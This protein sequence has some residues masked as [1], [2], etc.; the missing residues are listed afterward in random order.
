M[1]LVRRM[2]FIHINKTECRITYNLV[3]TY[4]WFTITS[5]ATVEQT[6]AKHRQQTPNSIRPSATF[7][8]SREAW[9][10]LQGTNTALHCATWTA[11]QTHRSRRDF[12]C[13]W[14]C[15]LQRVINTADFEPSSCDWRTPPWWYFIKPFFVFVASIY[16]LNSDLDWDSQ[17]GLDC[18][19]FL[20]LLQVWLPSAQR[21]PPGHELS[22]IYVV[23]ITNG[24]LEQIEGFYLQRLHAVIWM[25]KFKGAET[26][27]NCIKTQP[28]YQILSKQKKKKKLVKKCVDFWSSRGETRRFYPS[29]DNAPL[30]RSS[31][32]VW[33]S[34][35]ACRPLPA[36]Q[37]AKE[38]MTSPLYHP[39]D[40]LEAHSSA[41]SNARCRR[42]LTSTRQSETA[43]KFGQ[44]LLECADPAPS[45]FSE[46][47]LCYGFVWIAGTTGTRWWNPVSL[48]RGPL[49]ARGRLR[50]TKPQWE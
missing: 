12:I 23:I 19:W 5:L 2:H 16:I 32:S 21:R 43:C 20:F 48:G 28:R 42:G 13:A 30:R 7:V 27:Q 31:S 6:W 49:P 8:P 46:R 17:T 25:K 18:L 40:T 45:T 9:Y 10:Y 11:T 44:L 39:P 50:P 34:P 37:T 35:A 14:C 1:Y 22:S 33:A 41:G 24:E 36:T 15:Y 26:D 29:L 47:G 3:F 4:S 38:N